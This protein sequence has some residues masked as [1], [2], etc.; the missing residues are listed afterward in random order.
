MIDIV[1]DPFPSDHAMRGLWE[2]AWEAPGPASFQPILGRSLAHV[3][4]YEGELLVGFVNVAWDGGVH[5]FV[6]DTCVDR[7]YRRRGIATLLV[8]AARDAARA[9]GAHWLHVDFEPQLSGFYRACGFGPT[10]A[11]LIRL[12]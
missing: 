4:A 11:G 8:A 12:A 5:A 3:G 9:R 1:T 10:E 7:H 6:L 2:K